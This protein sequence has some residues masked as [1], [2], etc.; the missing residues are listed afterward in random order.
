MNL[1][2]IC[3]FQ[4]LVTDC[5]QLTNV[6]L[7]EGVDG[8]LLTVS[9]SVSNRT[10]LIDNLLTVLDNRLQDLELSWYLQDHDAWRQVA[11]L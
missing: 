9:D 3:P 5:N 6:A 10:Q 4:K 8:I 11:H 1:F 7:K 2:L